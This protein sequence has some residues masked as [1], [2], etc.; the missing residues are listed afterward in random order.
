[1][2]P[3]RF[4]T[5]NSSPTYPDA[6]STDESLRTARDVTTKNIG[7]LTE[8]AIIWKNQCKEL[9]L[10]ACDEYFRRYIQTA[11]RN[12]WVRLSWAN[13]SP[14]FTNFSFAESFLCTISRNHH[15]K[16]ASVRKITKSFFKNNWGYHWWSDSSS[17]SALLVITVNAV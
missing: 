15:L 1:M 14:D 12:Q 13:R 10:L 11:Y 16:K 5:Y 3:Y 2:N 17:H 8:R 6:L 9:R 4:C 7:P